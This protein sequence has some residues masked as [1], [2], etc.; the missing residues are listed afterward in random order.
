MNWAE[1]VSEMAK[2]LAA[3]GAVGVGGVIWATKV[4]QTH[5]REMRDQEQLRTR[6]YEWVEF[7]KQNILQLQED[8]L[9]LPSL[10]TAAG[11]GRLAHEHKQ[12]PS[13]DVVASL[14]QLGVAT[15]RAEITLSR[16]EDPEL[17][18][19]CAKLLEKWQKIFDLWVDDPSKFANTFSD[20]EETTRF[21]RSFSDDF[22]P[23][24]RRVLQGLILEQKAD[25][26]N[27]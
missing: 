15:R 23:L 20:I 26:L 3:S 1:A 25:I 22:L 4:A 6:R 18:A 12:Q 24:S 8:V 10:L 9:A 16:I 21:W 13:H 19:C 14:H 2:Y 17:S 5:D 11:L 27:S 7:Q